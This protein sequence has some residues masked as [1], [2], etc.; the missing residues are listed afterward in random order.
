[1]KKVL[2]IIIIFEIASCK[3]NKENSKTIPEEQLKDNVE[4]IEIYRNDQADRQT[5]NI[6]WSAVSKRDSLREVRIYQLLDSNKVT[7]SKDYHNAAM[8]FQHGGDSIAYGMAVKLMRKSV[9]LDSTANKWL[10]AAAIDR[11]LL[12]KDESQIY[13]TQYQKFG[14]DE[15]W[16]LGKMDTTKITDEERVEYGV[17]TLAEQR[18]KVKQMNR[19]KL[20]EL[21]AQ[22]ETIDE[23]I[24]VIKSESKKEPEFDISES[25]INSFGYNLMRQSKNE[26]ALKIFKLNTEMYPN[27]YNTWDSYGE[28]L[29]ALEKKEEGVKA[30]KKSLELN[31]KNK[32]AET[33]IEENK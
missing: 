29:L 28:C 32:N 6:D 24:E 30:Y 5:D 17:E 1:M 33:I 7:T 8:I 13:G 31:P 23:V 19:K 12:S 4:L 18:E 10:L 22:E 20:S 2:L 3:M 16:Q 14:N 26:E 15:P 11:Y 9:E 25:G 27:G 21:L